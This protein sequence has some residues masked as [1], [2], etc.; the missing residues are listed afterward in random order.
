MRREMSGSGTE[1]VSN[2]IVIIRNWF[3]PA[4][5]CCLILSQYNILINELLVSDKMQS[6]FRY[7]CKSPRPRQL[8]RSFADKPRDQAI[9][10]DLTEK[11]LEN[12]LN[13]DPQRSANNFYNWFSSV[14]GQKVV[15][16]VWIGISGLAA[17]YH[18]SSHWFFLDQVKSLYQS[19]TNGFRTKIKAEMLEL[20]NE[21]T[22]HLQLNDEE[23]ASL[24]IFVLDSL[25]EP[26]GWGELGRNGLVGFPEW[27]QYRSIT[28]V[29]LEKMRI[30]MG[31]SG[32]EHCQLTESQIVSDS[33]R[34]FAE[35]LVLSDD[36]KRFA[37]AREIE[38]TKMQPFIVH[39]TLAAALTLLNYNIARI[40]NK[41]LSL[42]S[43]PPMFRMYLY[44]GLLPTMVL[45]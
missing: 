39:G 5:Y 2:C 1:E 15:G 6:G 43:R 7:F 3:K 45:R 41:K 28:E 11:R 35:S 16:S 12:A 19:Y 23:V 36:A 22:K 17:L 34:L 31:A 9:K 20:I 18:V 29:P 32:S 30:G 10:F 27:F 13:Q 37:I 14:R 38:R 24:G 42:F 21:V 25:S 4:L 44:L 26:Y 40:M 8:L 33:G